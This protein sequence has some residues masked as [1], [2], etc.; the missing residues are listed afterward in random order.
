MYSALPLCQELVCSREQDG[1]EQEETWLSWRCLRKQASQ[2]LVLSSS[3]TQTYAN[4]PILPFLLFS[5]FKKQNK[6]KPKS[7]HKFYFP[8]SCSCSLCFPF[9]TSPGTSTSTSS[10][11]LNQ[12]R[13]SFSQLVPTS[14][15][16]HLRVHRSSGLQST[17]RH[18]KGRF[19]QKRTLRKPLTFM[20][21]IFL[22]LILLRAHRHW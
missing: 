17:G 8:S 19:V 16:T 18:A 20:L 11:P 14:L 6:N 5:L 9:P 3:P 7:P 12:R 10:N 21:I 4:S 1:P 2:I 15:L 13:Y 22:K